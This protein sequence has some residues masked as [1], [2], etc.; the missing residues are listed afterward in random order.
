MHQQAIRRHEGEVADGGLLHGERADLASRRQRILAAAIRLFAEHGFTGVA[1]RDIAAAASIKHPLLFYHFGS[2]ADLYLAAVQDQLDKLAAGLDGELSVQMDARARLSAFVEVYERYFTSVEPGL[3]VTLR[4]ING[5]P[6]DVAKAIAE[7]YDRLV[8]ARLEQ[9][10]D[11]GARTGAFRPVDNA[12]ACAMAIVSI[13]HGFLRA[14]TYAPGRFST[15]DAVDQ[16]LCYYAA[17]LLPPVA[18]TGC[19]PAAHA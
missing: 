6:P 5:L 1:T 13:L 19:S 4:E 2:K 7:S 16:V 9:I 3:T 8:I 17:S 10:I 12:A 15:A 11:E 18:Q 14:A